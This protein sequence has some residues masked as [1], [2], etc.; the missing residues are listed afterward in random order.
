MTGYQQIVNTAWPSSLDSLEGVPDIF[1]PR[2]RVQDRGLASR[3]A[4]EALSW[5][6]A[7]LPGIGLALALAWVG[8]ILS[9]VIGQRLHF[10][11]GKS[12]VSPIT[13][14]VILG[15]MIRNTVGVPK[16]YEQG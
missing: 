13:V 10:E 2:V 6:G 11:K 12:P 1:E 7:V 8:Y 5:I 16:S 15:L 9:E 14:A 3:G 4:H